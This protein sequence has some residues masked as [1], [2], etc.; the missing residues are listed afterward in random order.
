MK[1]KK[2]IAERTL[3]P[4]GQLVTGRCDLID[5]M[6]AAY[7]EVLDA[8]A[9]LINSFKPKKTV[10]EH[11][12]GTEDEGDEW[13]YVVTF[14]AAEMDELRRIAATLFSIVSDGDHD[15]F[16]GFHA[17][18]LLRGLLE[19][20][21]RTDPEVP[22]RNGEEADKF[23]D[24]DRLPEFERCWEA[25]SALHDLLYRARE[26]RPRSTRCAVQPTA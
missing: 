2:T 18:V 7:G 5:A 22:D 13:E 20:V 4:L 8:S 6:A 11:T 10:A 21:F 26:G 15:G 25:V 1:R 17:S 24:R 3:S 23:V 19:H 12:P 16:K 14:T 9:E